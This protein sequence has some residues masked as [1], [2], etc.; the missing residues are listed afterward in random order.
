MPGRP[1]R[2]VVYIT[3]TEHDRPVRVQQWH[4]DGRLWYDHVFRRGELVV[5]SRTCTRESH[6]ARWEA[7]CTITNVYLDDQTFDAAA[8]AAEVD[9]TGT[10]IT[11]KI[12]IEDPLIEQ[13]V[14]SLARDEGQDR[15]LGRLYTEQVLQL[16]ALHLLRYHGHT[17]HTV[18]RGGIAKAGLQRVL[19]YIDA[20]LGEPISLQSL[21]EEA[22][23]SRF[24]FAKQFKRR[25]GE[26]PYQYVIRVRIEEAK[27]LLRETDLPLEEIGAR[28]GYDSQSRFITLF[29]R[30]TGVTPARY[31][32][33]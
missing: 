25:M 9:P 4:E 31:R 7:G 6:L 1:A 19:D 11:T 24:H 10:D 20:H 2:E 30:L 17:A 5:G 16:L 33:G 3:D 18:Y 22:G 21:A 27:R 26:A 15:L 23:L 12:G 32:R 29:K 14:R 8:V 13:L 28:V